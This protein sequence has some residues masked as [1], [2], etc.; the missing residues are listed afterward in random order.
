MQ[1]GLVALVF[2]GTRRVVAQIKA[3]PM[4]VVMVNHVV[5]QLSNRLVVV[6]ELLV[7]VVGR[8][9]TSPIAIVDVVSQTPHVKRGGERLHIVI[10]AV[11]VGL[12]QQELE[13]DRGLA[14]RQPLM[15]QAGHLI[16]HKGTP[17]IHLQRG[18]K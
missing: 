10:A 13:M 5:I 2:H 4:L 1:V 15:L 7:V 12:G 9:G 3:E 16:R 17:D 14:E 8:N 18:L 6:E 11:G